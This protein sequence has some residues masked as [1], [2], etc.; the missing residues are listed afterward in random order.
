MPPDTDNDTLVNVQ[1]QR[2]LP[3]GLLV[4][5]D[6][7]QL[8]I[9]REREIAWDRKVRRR[10]RKLFK[11]GDKIKA[12]QLG[13]GHD[14]RLELSL[15]LAKNDPWSDLHTRYRLGQVVD[16]TVT[17][18]QTY[19]AF[20]EIEPSVTGLLHQTRLP[21]W[22]QQLSPENLFWPGDRV[23][24]AIEHIDPG[25]RK[26]GLTML[27][28]WPQ[29]WKAQDGQADLAREPRAAG[30]AAPA[31]D[32]QPAVEAARLPA[33]RWTVLVVEDDEAQCD[34]VVGWLQQ[35]GQQTLRA[36]RAEDG[37][38]ILAQ[39]RA[40]LVLMDFNLPG[41]SGMEALQLI[42]ARW[43]ATRRVL[44][45]DWTRASES[46]ADLDALFAGGG[47]LLVKP[48][49]P[50]DLASVLA[51]EFEV[52]EAPGEPQAEIAA[53]SSADL[54][55]AVLP[56]QR[57]LRDLLARLY[58][59]SGATH[60]V[61]FS[62]DPA[63]R[64]M[65]VLADHGSA[66]VNLDATVDLIYSPVRDVAEDRRLFRIEDVQQ[67]EARVRYLKPLL[68]FRSCLGVPVPASMAEHYALFLF[69]VRPRAFNDPLHEQYAASGA[70]ALGALLER[71]QFRANALEM[72]RLAL[73]GQLT[74]A[75]VHEINHQ[76]SP[77][78]FALSD[79]NRHYGAI[80]QRAA[81]PAEV[82]QNDIREA[83]EI[84][85]D[86]SRGVQR[87]TETARMFGRVTVQ[88]KEQVLQLVTVVEDVVHLVR[89]MAD[90]AN[91]TIDLQA[92]AA[93]PAVRTQAVQVQQILL[94]VVMNAIQQIELA[95][96]PDGGRVQIRL[97][98][99]VREHRPT[100]R[101]SVEDD[102]VG[103]HRE[104]WERVFELG[105]TTRSE[106]GSGLGLYITRS[107]VEA[108]GGRV[109]VAESHLLWGTTF[110][111]ELP[112]ALEQQP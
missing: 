50:S 7:G 41:M 4:S 69:S 91:V 85:R 16:G 62:L 55:R 65:S 109:Y 19:G 89:D 30:P 33:V 32:D 36:G 10:W 28:V 106:G 110:A 52:P 101:I 82:L 66:A 76:L 1:V 43:P 34:A 42:R 75:L 71:E 53:P 73:L 68:S 5:L 81:Q 79:L 107:L 24:V 64:K 49:L 100:L 35:A 112:A 54:L 15:R 8:G 78:N 26:L 60:V 23:R 22:A 57:L 93:L 88:S 90:R 111:V 95:G 29:R 46:S 31:D 83:R 37:L 86:L 74:R 27:R 87:L 80:A 61:L 94:N 102:A 44:M 72:Q 48:L 104:H 11:P 84:A 108:L 51:D 103:I 2:L 18:V 3:F 59:M 20:V 67:S 21:L 40:D 12:L 63:Q 96:R 38:A 13:V 14:N 25:H 56:W 39:Q 97:T 6:D 47:Q 92:P 9:I 98:E 105:F 58:V 99:S 70:L 45:T 77:I 17:G